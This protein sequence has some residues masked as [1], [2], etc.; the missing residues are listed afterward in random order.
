MT[1]IVADFRFALRLLRK[2]PGFTTVAVLVLALGIGAN[3]AVFGLVNT[4]LLKPRGGQPA[5]ALVSLYSRDTTKP[6]SYRAFSFANFTDLRA[7]PELFATLSAHNLAMV[8]LRDGDSTR[9][10]FVDIVT[11]EFFDTFG[12]TPALGRVFTA[13]EERPG[14][15][16]P[17]AIVSDALWRRL[18]GTPQVVGQSITLNGRAFT[19][20][21]VAPPGFGGSIVLFTPDAFVPTG[22]YDSLSNDFARDGY[23]TTLSDPRHYNL[24]LIGQLRPGVTPESVAPALKAISAEMAAAEPAELATREVTAAPISRL[25]IST[26]PPD[27]G[28]LLPV[29]ALLLGMSLV[30]LF[31]ASFNLAN[32]LLARNGAR[33]KEF[34]IRMAIG[35]SRTRMVR[36]LVTEG[37]VLSLLGGLG[38][39]ALAATA[40]RLMMAALAPLVPV[41][42]SFEA[43]PD[44]RIVFATFLFCLVSTIVFSLGPALA[45]SRTN[46]VPELKEHAGELVKRSRFAM[47]DVLVMAQLALSLVMLTVAGLFVRGAIDAAKTDPGFTFARGILINVDASLAGR[48]QAQTRG[49]YQQV[50]QRLRG[51]PGVAAAS[52]ASLI[53]FGEITVS[54]GVQK[55]GA[56][57]AG[58]RSTGTRMQIGGPDERADTAQLVDSIATSIGAGYFDALGLSITRGRDFTDAEVFAAGPV[59]VAIVDAPLAETLFGRE[60][61]V[62]QQIQYSG[63][64]EQAPPVV[65]QV[66]G[67]VPGLKQSLFDRGPVPHVY[68][69]L[70]AEFRSDVYF[71]VRTNA[72]GA[73]A[74][75]AELLMLPGLRR[76]LRE[77]DAS[78]PILRLET[79]AQYANRNFLLAIVRVGAGIFGVFGAVALVLASI[80]VYGV[81]AYIV[82]RR[83]REIG[84]RMALG[85]TPR[86]VVSLVV[87]DGLVLS[88]AG[89]AIGLGLSVLAAIAMRGMVYRAN[90]VDPTATV[91]AFVILVSAA[92]AASWIPAW[93]ATRVAPVTALRRD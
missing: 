84:I 88:G 78:L 40:T 22:M 53:P 29:S 85:A 35:G 90:G 34:A 56:P 64:D 37:F 67:V 63:R 79:R 87:R 65:L 70:S 42:V 39:L 25:S 7:R 27:D 59:H 66:I 8:G 81:K 61:P 19:V 51:T 89:L 33:A 28:E 21:G 50:Q 10:L 31:I 71:H 44:V 2:N 41:T 49:L 75:P 24:F 32:M 17:V 12:V 9:R 57:V 23:T 86:S 16:R 74:G 20:V 48:D 68:V 36:Q 54:H 45:L 43:T 13:D 18:G 11:R 46:L 72:A 38:G 15:D 62:G 82:S 58:A 60:D 77:V 4:L 47:R 52:F 6:N 30:V 5:G 3:S 93:R 14:A 55:P 92:L 83:T 1:S 69:P 73:S 91:V 80:G 76:T 26:S